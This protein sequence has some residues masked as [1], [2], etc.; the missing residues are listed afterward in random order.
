MIETEQ[1]CALPLCKTKNEVVRGK[2][3]IRQTLSDA[4]ESANWEGLCGTPWQMVVPDLKLRKNVTAD[5][6]GAGPQLPRIVVERAPEVVNPDDST[7]CLRTLKLTETLEAAQAVQRLH[8]M[9]KRQ[10]HITMN[11]ERESERSLRE[12]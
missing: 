12:P 5:K 8:R 6:E 2:S 4:W 9:E 1:F 3:W 10:S 11:A 7:S